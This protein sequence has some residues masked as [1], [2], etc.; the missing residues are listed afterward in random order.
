MQKSLCS[1]KQEENFS[2]LWKIMFETLFNAK[3]YIFNRSTYKL[4]HKSLKEELQK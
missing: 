3:E 1:V 4:L 2:I